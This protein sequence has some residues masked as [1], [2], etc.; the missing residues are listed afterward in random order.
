MTCTVCRVASTS[1]W[2]GGAPDESSMVIRLQ[3]K[4]TMNFWSTAKVRAQKPRTPTAT[5][6][7]MVDSAPDESIDGDQ[8]A[9]PNH[10]LILLD[11]AP[12]ESINGDQAANRNHNEIGGQQSR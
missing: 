12:D 8:A 11:S 10:T 3:V 2:L 9:S 4:H 6:G 7:R 1:L 5:R